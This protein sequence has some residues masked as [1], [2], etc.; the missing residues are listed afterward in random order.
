M[1]R[2]A[3]TLPIAVIDP[4]TQLWNE[5]SSLVY[6]RP[7][8]V[9]AF[10]RLRGDLVSRWEVTDGGRE[11]HLTPRAGVTWHDGAPFGAADLVH[12]FTLLADA[13]NTDMVK[14]ALS[15]VAAIEQR[16]D[17]AGCDAVVLRLAEP[18]P[19]FAERLARACVVPAHGLD[20]AALRAGAL[21]DHPLGTGPY[22]VVE[23]GDGW[24]TF[25]AHSGYHH[26]APA[27]ARI[28]MQHVADDADRAAALGSGCFDIG[29]IKPQHA[30]VLAGD[31]IVM[32]TIATRV[33]RAF[34]FSLGHPLLARPGV[35]RAL[36]S[37]IDRDELVAEALGGHGRPQYWPTPPSSWAS[38]TEPPPL[39]ADVAA[40]LLRANGWEHDDAGRWHVDGEPVTLRLC[41]LE[42]ETFR[43]TATRVIA[44]QLERFGIAVTY[45]P[46][47]W[48]TYHGMDRVGL[49]GSGFD[50]IV[51][52]WSGGVDPYDNLAIRYSST[53]AYNR[54]GYSDDELDELLHAAGL[55]TDQH[56]ALP[57]YRAALDITHRDSIMAPLVNAY[58]LFA[59]RRGLTGFEQFEVDSFYEFTQYAHQLRWATGAA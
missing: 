49:R 40:A 45:E 11:W 59:A 47:S 33:W 28:E 46:I 42:T 36:S 39:G 8:A 52:G 56:A 22:R 43:A 37:V 48:E 4:L 5:S 16:T 9:D 54:D 32:H 3:A 2:Y 20:G 10:G 35:R 34:T 24:M 7:L 18:T 21:T 44:A 1:L 58:Y 55:A 27:I 14:P 12:T 23:R 41:Y 13:A 26:G 53:G 25:A 17:D 6:S 19:G 57:L 31:E 29:Q 38:P 30:G 15:M 51:V 50:G